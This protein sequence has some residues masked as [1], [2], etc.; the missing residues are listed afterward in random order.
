MVT[1]IKIHERTKAKLDVYKM[2]NTSYNDVLDKLLSDMENKH[3][4]DELKLAY[5]EISTNQFEEFKEWE[6]LDL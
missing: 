4:F 6:N 5:S 2:K 1:T 3:L